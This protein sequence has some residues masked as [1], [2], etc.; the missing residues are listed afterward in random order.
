MKP[1]YHYGIVDY[2][3]ISYY[4]FGTFFV[5]P[6]ITIAIGSFLKYFFVPE[7]RQRFDKSFFYWGPNFIA[8]AVL[9]LFVDFSTTIQ[10]NPDELQTYCLSLVPALISTVF[11]SV[12]IIFVIKKYAWRYCRSYDCEDVDFLSGILI[13]DLLGIIML[14]FIWYNLP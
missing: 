8:T 4:I 14:F 7:H 11:F 5:V 10:N 1:L 6:I 9:L 3:I 12:L 13:P 2:R